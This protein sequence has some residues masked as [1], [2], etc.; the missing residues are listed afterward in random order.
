MKLI[1]D[2]TLLYELIGNMIGNGK[3][4]KRK[5]KRSDKQR[6][7]QERFADA[8]E[9]AKMQMN[10]AARKAK[11]QACINKRHPSAYSVAMA[12]ALNAP[13]VK[14][15]DT[16]NYYGVAGDVIKVNA[17]DDFEVTRVSVLIKNRD[18]KLIEC[19]DAV[20][21]SSNPFTWRYTVTTMNQNLHD[22]TI[23]ATAYDHPGNE[24][25]LEEACE[26]I[27]LPAPSA[28]RKSKSK[29]AANKSRKS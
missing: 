15:I 14:H 18:G 22:T 20:E 19:G 29:P 24:G 13:R 9:Y 23:L 27:G 1:I 3:Q 7:Q 5:Q 4:K 25:N 28:V 11:Y 12:D 6:A 26:N 21:D 2:N 10:D 8:S 16:G 17:V